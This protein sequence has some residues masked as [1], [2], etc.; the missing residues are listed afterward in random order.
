MAGRRGRRGCET[1][2]R[3]SPVRQFRVSAAFQQVP[4][5]GDERQFVEAAALVGWRE[6]ADDEDARPERAFHRLGNFAYPR[7]FSRFRS[8]VTSVNSWKLRLWSDGGKTR[9]T[10]MRDRSARFTG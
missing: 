4:I 2:A 9:T 6:D 10:R 8:S 5:I 3:V 1:G 7:P